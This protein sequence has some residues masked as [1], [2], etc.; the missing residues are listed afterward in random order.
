M[1]ELLGA[2]NV[3]VGGDPSDRIFGLGLGTRADPYR[4]HH[5]CFDLTFQR[6]Y[7]P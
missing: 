4:T 6:T 5:T 2:Y 3:Y 1:N 7:Q